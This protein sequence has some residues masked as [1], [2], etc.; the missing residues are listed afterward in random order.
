[1]IMQ[2]GSLSEN[3]NLRN[4]YIG[5]IYIYHLCV[6]SGMRINMKQ[7]YLTRVFCPFYFRQYRHIT[8]YSIYL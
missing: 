2:F 1:M 7:K 8:K 4:I 6:H 3:I 5:Y